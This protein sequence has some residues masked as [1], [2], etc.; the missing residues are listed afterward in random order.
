MEIWLLAVVVA[1]IVGFGVAPTAG[2]IGGAGMLVGGPVFLRG[3]RQ[4]RARAIAAAVPDT[5]ERIG[6]ELR[7]G[8][9]VATGLDAIA[10]GGGPLAPDI[11]R[12]ETRVRLGASHAN[13]LQEWA[14]QRPA[15]GVEATAG[16]LALTA[17]VGGRA[18]DALD[19]LGSS[20]R[21][22]LAVA[23]EARALSAQARYSAWV[24]G[25]AP[26]GYIIASAVID[27]RS[28]HA[29][30]GTNAGRL[31]AAAGLTLEVLGA[32]W[33]RAIVRAGDGA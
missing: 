19:A 31:C 3:A 7:A 33:M 4:R 24:I 13:A 5:L 8:G 9:T 15:A 6:A 2:V 23:A 1:T 29:L 27:P 20:L 10:R 30:V 12:L 11:T 28:M 21:D 22:R 17:T 14:R 18:A 26:L 25:V 32:V 16:A